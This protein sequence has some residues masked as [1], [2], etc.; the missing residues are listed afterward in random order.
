M[1]RLHNRPA[2]ARAREIDDAIIAEQQ[3]QQQA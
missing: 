3:K 2:A 1:A